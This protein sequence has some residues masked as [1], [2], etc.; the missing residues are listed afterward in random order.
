MIK[1]FKNSVKMLMESVID[2]KLQD[3]IEAVI[4]QEE[5]LAKEK[6]EQ[7]ENAIKEKE[8]LEKSYGLSVKAIKEMLLEDKQ[9][10]RA[11]KLKDEEKDELLL[12]IDMLANVIES[13]DKDAIIYAFVAYKYVA[14]AHGVLFFN[15]V[16]KMSKLLKGVVNEI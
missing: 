6:R 11:S 2:G 15:R 9:K 1:P 10:V 12:V 5:K 7:E 14:K 13:E 16:R 4:Q 8:L 3:P